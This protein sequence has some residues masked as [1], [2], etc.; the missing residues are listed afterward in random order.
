MDSVVTW[1]STHLGFMPPQVAVLLTSMLPVVELRGGI[2]LAR[3]LE[4]PLWQAVFFSVLGN[5]IPVPFILLFI[6]KI[7]DWLRPTKHFG[8]LVTK[9][10]ARAM[11]RSDSVAKAE[12][13]GLM[14][15][16][17]VP[18]P[19]TGGWTGALIAALL[20]IDFK[21]ATLAILCGIAMAAT[22]VGFIAYGIF[23]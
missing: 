9:M 8:K 10:E 21:K 23:G 16:V 2:P 13:W 20:E 4:L 22:I 12:F 14:V 17:G 15:F 3:L 7:F 5:V 11:K 19:G 18:L 6:R 1:F